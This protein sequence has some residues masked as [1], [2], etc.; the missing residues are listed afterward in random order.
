M[1]DEYI[2]SYV[3]FPIGEIQT[4]D[5]LTWDYICKLCKQ[6]K[7]EHFVVKDGK[8]N[9]LTEKD[10]PRDGWVYIEEVDAKDL[11]DGSVTKDM[12]IDDV[13]RRIE[14][15]FFERL[16]EK[17]GWGKEEIKKMYVQVERDVLIDVIKELLEI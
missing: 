8:G 13:I 2:V 11:K 17:T 4:D 5:Y 14:K 9:V 7:I 1:G 6:A 3:K 12:E 16:D 15:E 10:F